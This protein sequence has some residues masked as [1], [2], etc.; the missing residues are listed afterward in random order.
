MQ[1]HFGGVKDS[2][3][4]LCKASACL[5]Q[6]AYEVCE[7]DALELKELDDFVDEIWEMALGVD[8][9]DCVACVEDKNMTM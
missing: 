8:L 7:G 5:R 9:S 1:K 4:C 6:I 3:W 2:N